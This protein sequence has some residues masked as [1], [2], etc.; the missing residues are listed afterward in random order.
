MPLTAALHDRARLV[1]GT[2]AS[3]DARGQ[4]VHLTAGESISYGYLVYAVG[5]TSRLDHVDGAREHAFTVSEYE[6]ALALRQRLTTVTAG[7]PVVVVGG[8]LTGIE[9]AAELAELRPKLSVTL[10]SSGQV[11]EGLNEKARAR[12]LRALASHSVE[13]IEGSR[14]TR[15]N[16]RKVEL[17]DGRMLAAECA[18]VAMASAVPP[19]ALKSGLPADADGRL[20]VDDTL[21]CPN[22]PNIVGAGDAVAID[23]MPLRMSCQAAIPLG[24]HAADTILRRIEGKPPKAV[25]PKFI[26]QCISLGRRAAV[27]QRTD[28]KDNPRSTVVSGRTGA[29]IKEQICTSALKWGVNPR[30]PV[31]Y[32]WS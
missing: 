17:A 20:L 19:L 8:G 23:G 10:V 2:V 28:S 27:V 11:A 22:S 9:T 30:R 15:I 26:S 7:A 6:S 12:I 32:T 4:V 13:V 31:M 5:S 24:A 16:E 1:V 3:I 25:N 29:L 21:T 18:V 14:V